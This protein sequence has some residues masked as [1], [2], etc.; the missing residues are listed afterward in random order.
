MFGTAA[1]PFI[2]E[3]SALTMR[4]VKRLSRERMSMIFGLIQPML[5]WLILFGNLFQKTARMQS[6]GSVPNYIT[7]LTGGVVAMT[8]LNSGLAGGVDLLFD[9]ESGFLERLLSAPI[10]RNAL[11]LSRFIFVMAVTTVQLV[12]ILLVA[13]ILFGVSIQSGLGGV[14]L[15]MVVGMMF[16]LGLIAISLSMAMAIKSH[17]NFFALMGFMTLPLIFLSSALVPM[18]VIPGWMAFLARFNPMTYATDAIRALILGQWASA[19]LLRVLLILVLFDSLCIWM[20]GRI[21]HR[22]VG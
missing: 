9:K 10:S 22:Q 12:V 21:F 1:N 15:I 3:V 2:Q 5:F 19:H 6:L 17:G 7:F 20:S 18:E 13:Y 8:V 16:G 14:I 11:I 4:W